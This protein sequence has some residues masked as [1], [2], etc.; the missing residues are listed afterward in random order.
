MKLFFLLF[1]MS[2][3]PQK[4]NYTKEIQRCAKNDEQLI[5]MV[6]LFLLFYFYYLFV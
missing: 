1:N 4:Y 2:A 6:I 5:N 3:N